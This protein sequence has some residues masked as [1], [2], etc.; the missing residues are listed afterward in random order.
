MTIAAVSST[1]GYQVSKYSNDQPPGRSSGFETFQSPRSQ[2]TCS[3]VIHSRDTA[4]GS[5]PSPESTSPTIIRIVSHTGETAGLDAVPGF[6]L[7]RESLHRLETE[8]RESS[9]FLP[10]A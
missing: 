5:S 7:D 4:S 6:V 10:L 2:S 1:S 9:G 3:F 8:H